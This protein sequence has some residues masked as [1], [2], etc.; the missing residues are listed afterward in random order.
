[1]GILGKGRGGG[2]G[3]GGG[4][5]DEYLGILGKGILPG[6]SNPDPV[7]FALFQTRTRLAYPLPCR[8]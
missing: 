3:G 2:G 7:S 4:G 5:G 6:F 1:M 8:F